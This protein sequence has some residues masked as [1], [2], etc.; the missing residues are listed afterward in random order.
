MKRMMIVSLALIMVLSALAVADGMGAFSAFKSGIGA[1]ALAMG[2]AF[3]AVAEGATAGFWNPAALA[4][5]CNWV[6]DESI[7]T[8]TTLN[9][10][11]PSDMEAMVIDQM[12][13]DALTCDADL[14]SGDAL[15]G[16]LEALDQGHGLDGLFCGFEDGEFIRSLVFDSSEFAA[17]SPVEK[18]IAT[19]LGVLFVL[20]NV[21]KFRFREAGDSF[22]DAKQIINRSQDKGAFAPY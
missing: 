9:Y 1:R 3:V 21:R 14:M 22:F 5:A 13:A 17:I 12:M 7:A 8:I 15:G 11:D 18:I 10:L 19:N 2:S 6:Q 4:V 20:E 16:L